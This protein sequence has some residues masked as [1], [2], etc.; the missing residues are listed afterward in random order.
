M[1]RIP[2]S[3][4]A[5]VESFGPELERVLAE[6]SS[7][8]TTIALVEKLEEVG[9]FTSF[10]PMAHLPSELTNVEIVALFGC[11]WKQWSN[12]VYASMDGYLRANGERRL[13]PF[14]ELLPPASDGSK[15][16][17]TAC[18]SSIGI[19]A[20][21]SAGKTFRNCKP[22]VFPEHTVQ[23]FK[24]FLRS[25]AS[26]LL[27][28]AVTKKKAAK[29]APVPADRWPLGVPQDYHALQAEYG[30]FI[31]GRV[32]KFNKIGRNF[33]DLLGDVW[34]RLMKANILEKF[35]RS[36]NKRLP[37]TMTGQ[38]AS[39]YLGVPFPV[40]T[41][42]FKRYRSKAKTGP[43]R[44]RPYWMPEPIEGDVMSPEAVYHTVDIED[45][46]DM[47]GLPDNHLFEKVLESKRPR[48]T[49]YGFKAYLTRAIYNHMCNIFRSV[50]RHHKER[51]MNPGLAL[52]RQSDGSYHRVTA[53]DESSAW[54]TQL[55]DAMSMDQEVMLAIVAKIH[56]AGIDP[57]SDDGMD[58][59]KQI[60]SMHARVG[61]E[62]LNLMGKGM[63]LQQAIKAQKRASFRR[64]AAT[65]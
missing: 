59:L 60:G 45:L 48:P 16:R 1:G 8:M 52:R 23:A 42:A 28:G 31:A 38:Q 3:V 6:N 39:E 50:D 58:M 5:L 20:L 61:E 19:R 57:H 65:A 36:A 40:W 10:D 47:V 22:P 13:A 55:V 51:V 9:L 4:G 35:A 26:N 43:Y 33:E 64:V 25:A 63:S 14:H 53:V 54:E 46:R 27:G 56:R 21:M 49:N 32:R 17:K 30:D 15:C 11:T 12:W 2:Q 37:P 44:H 24:E 41:N 7:D 34:L 18:R 29:P 62:V